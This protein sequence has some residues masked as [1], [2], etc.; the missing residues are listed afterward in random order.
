MLPDLN[1]AIDNAAPGTGSNVMRLREISIQSM[2]E[3]TARARFKRAVR[4]KTQVPAQ[5]HGYKL[6][7][8]ADFHEAG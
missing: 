3:G 7:G 4:A 1:V 6:G 2:V 8:L 5:A